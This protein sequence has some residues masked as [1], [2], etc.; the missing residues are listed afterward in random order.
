[1]A[2]MLDDADKE[3]PAL[4]PPDPGRVYRNYLATCRRLGVKPVPRES[5]TVCG[6]DVPEL[7]S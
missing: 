3:S 6:G 2:A 5:L 7:A 1:M 4:D